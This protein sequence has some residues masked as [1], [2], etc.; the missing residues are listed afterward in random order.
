MIKVE[1][2]LMLSLNLAAL[3]KF[4]GIKV[5]ILYEKCAPNERGKTPII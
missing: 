2:Y 1:A 4:V 3:I 5:K